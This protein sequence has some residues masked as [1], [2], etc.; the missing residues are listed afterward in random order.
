MPKI[1]PRKL[2]AYF[3]V[4][5]SLGCN[6]SLEGA[7]RKEKANVLLV[8]IDTLRTDRLSCYSDRY[9]KTV[10]IDRL[11]R[12][13]VVFERAF[14]HNPLTLPSHV[15]IMLG[16]T[17]LYHGVSENARS[18]VSE[19]FLTLAEFLKA[20]GYMTAGFIGAFPLDSR[21][22]LNQGFDVYDESYPAK[23]G[24]AF[25]YPERPAEKVIESALAWLAGISANKQWFCWVHLWDPH[26][27]Y[28]PPEPYATRYK[29]DPYTGEVAYVDEQVG[30]LFEYLDKSHLKERTLIILTGDHG[31]ALGEHGEMTHGYF[32]YNSTIWVPLIIAGPGIKPGR[33]DTYVAH[34]DLFPTVADYLGLP[35]PGHLQGVS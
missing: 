19:E 21:F 26:A 1:W 34:V 24:R 8:T 17:P 23:T 13:G 27:P 3:L 32:A 10:N 33:Q 4:F 28:W 12:D 18:V 22:G 29:N 14:A 31:E 9:L 20:K 11:A 16:A 6:L 15:N 2:K 7:L 30:K 5:F 35:L 25:V